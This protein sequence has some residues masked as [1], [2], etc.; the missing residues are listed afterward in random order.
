LGRK[1]RA[2]GVGDRGARKGGKKEKKIELFRHDHYVIKNP[3]FG[4][5]PQ[6]NVGE[7]KGCTTEGERGG[8]IGFEA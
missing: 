3:H 2:A 5:G 8:R 4:R 1:E 6:T 7:A